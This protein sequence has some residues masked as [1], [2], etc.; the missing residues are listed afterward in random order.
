[1]NL[2]TVNRNQAAVSYG[3]FR[4]NQ[5]RTI[6]F[7]GMKPYHATVNNLGFRDV[8]IQISSSD[9]NTK[10][11]IL[12]VGDSLTFGLFID[13]AKTYPYLLQ[14]ALIETKQNAIVLNAGIGNTTITDH[15]AYLQNKGL[16][17]HPDVVIIN[18]CSNDIAE[19]SGRSKPLYGQ[20]ISKTSNPLSQWWQ[21][22]PLNRSFR[23]WYVLNKYN[24]W[25]HK[26]KDER[27]TI[28]LKNKSRNLDD[29]LYVCK[30]YF[31]PDIIKTPTDPKVLQNWNK[32]FSTLEQTI[33]I[34]QK[35]NIKLIF[36]ITPE[37]LSV[38]N[39]LE[40]GYQEKLKTFL[41][42]H[43]I[44]YIDLSD[45]FKKYTGDKV[46]LFNDPPRDYHLSGS[47]NK[48][49]VE[50]LLPIIESSLK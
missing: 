10:Q 13:D 35:N 33:D 12:T 15:L 39:Q 37:F 1:M 6:L 30:N 44:R 14:K 45:E 34:L 40:S 26:I 50:K 27:I 48:L 28:I 5:S 2:D 22:M 41:Q 8:G 9:L 29:I 43:K 24:H 17:L 7:P 20:L 42:E 11:K 19:L 47:G 21:N 25:L 3:Y 46:S 31:A 38:F 16:S 32:Y 23:R 49:L 18:F 36:F 4:P